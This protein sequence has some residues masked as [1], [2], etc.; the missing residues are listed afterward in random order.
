MIKKALRIELRN[1]RVQYGTLTTPTIKGTV[2]RDLRW[3][4]LDINRK[5]FSRAI[6]AYHKILILFKGHLTIYK[7]RSSV[8]TL[9]NS[10]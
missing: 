4:L 6:V 7:R 8:R 3:V 1:R 5:L 9:G 2:S 10:R